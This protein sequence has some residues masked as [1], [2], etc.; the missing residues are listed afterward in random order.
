[1][2][3]AKPINMSKEDFI[4]VLKDILQTIEN[5]DSYEGNLTWLMP[6]EENAEHPFDIIATYRIGNSVGQGSTRMIG[7]W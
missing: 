2:S 6:E 3:A 5:D 1:M 4:Q 7:E